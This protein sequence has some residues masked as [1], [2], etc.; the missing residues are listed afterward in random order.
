MKAFVGTS[1]IVRYL[2]GDPPDMQVPAKRILDGQMTL[3][4][5]DIALVET[6]Y[7]LLSFYKIPR[8]AL[9]DSLIALVQKRNVEIYGFQKEK[10]I[11][12]LLLCRTSARVSFADALI[13]AAALQEES[14]V[15]T[16]DE[17]FPKEGI[18]LKGDI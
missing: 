2:T 1:V 11:R 14:L 6:A 9:V 10:V 5:T 15:Y 17:R 7:V 13:W 16:F 8:G 18:M 3:T 4:I 12:A